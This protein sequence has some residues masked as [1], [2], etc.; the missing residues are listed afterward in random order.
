MFILR[1]PQYYPHYIH[2][3]VYTLIYFIVCNAVDVEQCKMLTLFV[4]SIHLSGHMFLN[5]YDS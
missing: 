3:T 2:S 1:I 4:F 5:V